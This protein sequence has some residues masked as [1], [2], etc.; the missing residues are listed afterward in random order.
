MIAITPQLSS[1]KVKSGL[2]VKR[3]IFRELKSEEEL[4]NFQHWP[5]LDRMEWRF[6]GGGHY[7]RGFGDF[8]NMASSSEKSCSIEL[9]LI[10]KEKQQL[11]QSQVFSSCQLCQSIDVANNALSV[12]KQQHNNFRPTRIWCHNFDWINQFRGTV[13]RSLLILSQVSS[14]RLIIIRRVA[15]L[16]TVLDLGCPPMMLDLA[17]YYWCQCLLFPQLKKYPI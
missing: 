8:V 17:A 5:L 1:Q 6:L 15:I 12:T 4:I 2:T 14:E 7:F 13:E 11:K 3:D 16:M 9:R 10:A